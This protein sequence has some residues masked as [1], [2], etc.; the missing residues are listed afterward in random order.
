[1]SARDEQHPAEGE[2]TCPRCDDEPRSRAHCKRCNGRGIVSIASLKV[3][4]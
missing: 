1:M 4:V 3:G 2:C